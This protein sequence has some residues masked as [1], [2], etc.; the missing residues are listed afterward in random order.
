ML[1]KIVM[2]IIKVENL[3]NMHTVYIN[4]GGERIELKGKDIYWKDWVDYRDK[5]N[6]KGK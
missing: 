4:I 3:L 5:Y 6:L 2:E 1:M